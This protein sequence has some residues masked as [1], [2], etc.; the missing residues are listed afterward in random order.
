MT[1]TR[2]PL[3]DFLGNSR[4]VFTTLEAFIEQFNSKVGNLLPCPFRNL[5]LNLSPSE[6]NIW[7]LTGQNRAAFLQ[8]RISQRLS[9]LGYSNNLDQI[10][11]RDRCSRF[12][13]KDIV[14]SGEGAALVI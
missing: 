5:F 3:C 2:H 8:L 7:K 9:P 11:S 14:E 12:A 10:V 4:I 1:L 6:L 13:T